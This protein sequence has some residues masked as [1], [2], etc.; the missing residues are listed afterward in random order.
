MYTNCRDG[1]NFSRAADGC[2]LFKFK[3]VDV[4]VQGLWAEYDNVW[5]FPG[6]RGSDR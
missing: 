6:S 1:T 2:G 4:R 5:L 3:D